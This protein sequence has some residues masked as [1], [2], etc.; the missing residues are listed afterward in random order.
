MLPKWYHTPY[1][2]KYY[3][4]YYYYY[5]YYYYYY[6]YYY[7]YY[8]YY[9]SGSRGGLKGEVLAKT[10]GLYQFPKLRNWIFKI[11][12][13]LVTPSVMPTRAGRQL[14]TFLVEIDK[15]C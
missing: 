4:Y 15:F 14:P 7:Y 5:C 12:C 6:C 11:S 9:Y 2:L 8:Y 3:Y 13:M 10:P 1:F